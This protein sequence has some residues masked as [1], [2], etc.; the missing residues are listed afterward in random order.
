M[1]VF[2]PRCAR[3]HFESAPVRKSRSKVFSKKNGAELL[4]LA[5]QIRKDGTFKHPVKRFGAP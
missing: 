3:R 4:R 1:R 2:C 5:A